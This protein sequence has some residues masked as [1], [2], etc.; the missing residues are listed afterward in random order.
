MKNKWHYAMGAVLL[1]M[2]VFI[3]FYY[4][5]NSAPASVAV[6]SPEPVAT[7]TP[8]NV[9]IATITVPL[10]T[11]TPT[12]IPATATPT[13]TSTS[14]DV[15]PTAT[16]THH[17]AMATATDTITKP[18]PSAGV[19]VY[20]TTLSLPTYPFANY[21]SQEVDP[22]YNM[23]L[24]YL[25]RSE[26]EASSPQAIPTNYQAV[27]LENAYLRLTF[28]PSLGG[29]LYS[30]R[31][32]ATGQEVFY[33]NAVVKPSVYGPLP[34]KN[35]VN[36]NWWL[37][38]GGMEWAYPVQEH[39]YRWGIPWTY[40]LKQTSRSA[41]IILSDVAAD[42]VGMEVAITLSADSATFLV[43]PRLIN[44]DVKAVP[45]QGWLNAAL[46]LGA[47]SM[48]PQTQF[49]IPIKTVTVHSRGEAGWA[50]PDAHHEVSWP[51][52]GQTD[53]REYYQWA[54][55]LGIFMPNLPAPFMGAYNPDTDLA[56]ARLIEPGQ[57]AGN[58]LFAFSQTF[59]DRSYTNDASQYFEIWGGLNRGFWAED[60]VWV[61]PGE[62]LTWQEQWWPLAQL[63]GLTW[64]NSHTAIHLT[65]AGADYTLTALFSRLRQGKLIVSS[66]NELI[67]TEP[68]S[69]NPTQPL[70]WKFTAPGEALRIQFSDNSQE[71]LLDF[72]R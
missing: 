20:E 12:N 25:N 36:P 35:G 49:V 51:L 47:G 60:D 21:L 64:A 6:A 14:T 1:I 13:P 53:L 26:Y 59:R 32:K 65:P 18:T 43:N 72:A 41:T 40:R 46:A 11:V 37:A 42:R 31:V 71:V 63:G 23:P 24:F 67:L 70:S 44:H 4:K 5:F 33:H 58:K 56:V 19:K 9:V 69:A 55:Y 16:F 27:V 15:L 2:A 22:L 28:I 45:L 3:S 30:A 68:F 52:I 7:T 54:N 8:T 57:V 10:L 29:R 66:G 38:T 34:S 61:A 17:V 62:T 48:S 50:V 39:G